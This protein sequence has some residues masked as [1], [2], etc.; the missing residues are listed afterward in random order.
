M[1]ARRGRIPIVYQL[2]VYHHLYHSALFAGFGN[3][4]K[5]SDLEAMVY[6]AIFYTAPNDVPLSFE[7]VPEWEWVALPP[8]QQQ[9]LTEGDARIF[10]A[11]GAYGGVFYP[12]QRVPMPEGREAWPIHGMYQAKNNNVL[13]VKHFPDAA[14]PKAPKKPTKPAKKPGVKSGGGPKSSSVFKKPSLKK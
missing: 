6:K 10:K 14:T 7:H 11:A 3:S 1:I 4:S 12:F 9:R 8:R 2:V 13:L 5:Q